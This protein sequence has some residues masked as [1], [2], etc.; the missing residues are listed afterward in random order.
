MNKRP[1]FLL[2][3][4]LFAMY[5]LG[6]AGAYLGIAPKIS[7]LFVSIGS[8][9]GLLLGIYVVAKHGTT[10]ESWAIWPLVGAIGIT[11]IGAL[12]KIMH[13]PF[14]NQMLIAGLGSFCAL[15]LAVFILKKGKGRLDFIKLLWVFVA[16]IGSLMVIMH[17]LPREILYLREAI[18]W[19]MILDFVMLDRKSNFVANDSV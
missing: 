19:I 13:W 7:E 18:F 16:T 1:L 6:M 12:W 17:Y 14:A 15:Y 10:F 5:T 4:I 11:A 2:L 3:A 8:R 9:L